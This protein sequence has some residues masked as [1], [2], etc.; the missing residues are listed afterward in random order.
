MTRK[1]STERLLTLAWICIASAHSLPGHPIPFDNSS[2]PL[3]VAI[4]DATGNG[5]YT[6]LA[7]ATAAFSGV[8]G[9]INRPWLLQLNDGYY[10]ET[11][12]SFLGQSFGPAG[13]LTI[14]PATGAH[15]VIEFTATITHVT[16]RGHIVLGVP[17]DRNWW[18]DPANNSISK[19]AFTID[20]SNTVGGTTRD[21]TFRS[22][23]NTPQYELLRLMG[24]NDGVVIKNL[25]IEN[26]KSGNNVYAC[27]G[28]GAIHSPAIGF[29]LPDDCLIQ[30][31]QLTALGS[32]PSSSGI[33][34][35]RSNGDIDSGLA[36]RNVRVLGN[37][38]ASRQR[39]VYISCVADATV[40]H[41]DIT[42][43]GLSPGYSHQGIFHYTANGATGWKQSIYGNRISIT[44]PSNTSQNV[45]GIFLDVGDGVMSGT[46]YVYNNTI[47]EMN[48]IGLTSPADVRYRCISAANV[49][50]H[51]YFLHNSIRMSPNPLITGALPNRVAG[52]S[53][54][55]AMTTGSVTIRNNI[56][57]GGS[58]GALAALI[59]S[60]SSNGF[61]AD[62]ND[63]FPAESTNVG[64]LE[65]D[66]DSPYKT[67]AE[68]QAGGYDPH[69]IS[70]DPWVAATAYSGVWDSSLHFDG[71]PG[72]AYRGAPVGIRTDIDG[73]IRCATSPFIGADEPIFTPLSV[74]S[75]HGTPIPPVGVTNLQTGP[76]RIHTAR[77]DSPV[78]E[79]LTAWSCTGF[80]GTGVIPPQGT[81]NSVAFVA[82]T[83]ESSTIVWH[84]RVSGY[85]LA[86]E[87]EGGTVYVHGAASTG[88]Y[89]QSD[90]TLSIEA[91]PE[92]G[93][94]FLNWSG[95]LA[96]KLNSQTLLLDSP[97]TIRAHYLGPFAA[98]WR[99]Y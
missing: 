30:N 66:L 51:Y 72:P 50:S 43:Q 53:I 59:S 10:V 27:I 83:T 52:I 76:L 17:A 6:T 54:P 15:P 58:T 88:G 90:S 99:V 45:I 29:R 65:S 87:S 49:R 14:K 79:N 3:A 91:V 7:Q 16:F 11:E 85:Y 77:V 12:D 5:D 36:I 78:Y 1:R 4:L 75:G 63:L 41:N 64:V 60:A 74:L 34:I 20:G 55:L 61:L 67:F 62:G 97:K 94:Q 26:S 47:E 42:I 68:W 39:G 18:P 84:W 89:F 46:Y 80:T 13:S 70:L 23:I 40:A 48:V 35:F 38:I 25:I 81:A 92:D 37:T 19:D 73:M 21:L 33:F 93:Y 2:G 44:C 8:A 96:G 82:D 69:G 32:G 31:C 86:V 9:G 28:L 56:I 95:D 98:N 71:D 24:D 57:R 22:V